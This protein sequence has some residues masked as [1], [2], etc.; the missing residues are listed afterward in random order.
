MANEIS[1]S[2]FDF[3]HILPHHS[4]LIIENDPERAA[5]CINRI[6][7]GVSCKIISHPKK[8]LSKGKYLPLP[9]PWRRFAFV[10]PNEFMGLKKRSFRISCYTSQRQALGFPFVV[11]DPNRS[12]TYPLHFLPK[13]V[14]SFHPLLQ[15]LSEKQ[16]L[17]LNK[18]MRIPRSFFVLHHCFGK[19]WPKNEML[20][21]LL[22]QHNVHHGC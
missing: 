18:L 22:S 4:I 1:I 14:L 11:S 20:M 17:F 8:H 15:E 2:T 16:Y 9:I 3:Q 6:L 13:K 10:F 21:R 5:A 19:Q 7:A 12:E